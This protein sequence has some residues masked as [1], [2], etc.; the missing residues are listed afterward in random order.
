MQDI[1][2]LEAINQDEVVCQLVLR[3]AGLVRGGKLPGFIEAIGSDADLDA[4][5][6]AT[7]LELARDETFLLAAEDHMRASPCLH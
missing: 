7:V 4:E 2:A 1:E 5:T 3:M 6:K